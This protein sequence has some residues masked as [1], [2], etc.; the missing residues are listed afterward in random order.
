MTSDFDVS[1]NAVAQIDDS[2]TEL[3]QTSLNLLNLIAWFNTDSSKGGVSCS[4]GK[5]EALK[6]RLLKAGS[7]NA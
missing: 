7:H 4:T 3:A 5:T 2:T 6:R 1:R